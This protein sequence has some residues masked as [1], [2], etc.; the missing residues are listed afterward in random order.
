[1]SAA[2]LAL[3]MAGGTGGHIFPAL[4]VAKALQARGWQVRWLGTPGSMEAR[5]VP[6]HG[7]EMDFLNVKG[8]RGK[9]FATLLA[10]PFKVLSAVCQG[11]SLVKRL[12]PAVV[13]GLGGYASGPGGVA[14]WLAGKPLVIHE[15]NAI[16]GLTNKILAKL[17]RVVLSGFPVRFAT[18]AKYAVTGNP[19]RDDI[20]RLPAPAERYAEHDGP[21]RLLVVGGSLGAQV[22]NDT[23]PKALAAMAPE[24]RPQV[25]HQTGRDKADAVRAAYAAAGLENSVHTVAPFI[26]DMRAAYA[27][28]DLV[29]C[30]AGALTVA[31]VAAA[32]VAALFVPY[33]HAVDDH[34]S[35]NARYLTDAGAGVLLSQNALNPDRLATVLADRSRADCLKLAEAAR[36]LAKADATD[37]VV[38]EVLSVAQ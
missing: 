9:G 15:Q 23:V 19:V 3:I 12:Q 6:Q 1:M 17:A 5:L 27:W 11:L 35:A 28:A 24:A 21:L 16:P 25:W 20:A 38:N 36:A 37:A 29:L 10:A 8:L 4:A 31:E 18:S 13:L 22:F 14:A 7:I 34:Q 32:G 33:P 30:R 2:P 26:D